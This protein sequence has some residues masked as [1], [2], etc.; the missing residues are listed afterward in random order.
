MMSLSKGFENHGVVTFIDVFGW[1]KVK[2]Y[3]ESIEIKTCAFN[4]EVAGRFGII[5]KM[6]FN[7][8]RE[9]INF[10]EFDAFVLSSGFH[11]H[12]FDV[13]SS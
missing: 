11:S 3:T 5:I 7:I 2:D 1:T 6:D 13:A 9:K 8:N 4:D 10:S 12:G